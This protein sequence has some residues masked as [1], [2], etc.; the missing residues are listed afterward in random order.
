MKD[1]VA[2]LGYLAAATRFRRISE[3]LQYD[4]DKIYL[5]HGIDFKASWFSVF[6]TVGASEQPLT[7]NEIASE[8]GFTHITVK[9]VVREMEEHGLLKIS[10]HP[11]DKRAKH[12]SI[13]A[14]G[15][16]T[17]IQLEKVWLPFAATLKDLMTAGHPD[18]LN[19]VNRIDK[20]IEKLPIHERIKA[21][22]EAKL[23]IVDYRPSLKKYFYELAGPWLLRVLNG[24]LEE[25]DKFTLQNPDKAYLDTG[26]FVFFAMHKNKVIG[27]VALKRLGENT[28][29]FAKLFVDPESRKSGAA[30]KL[31]ERCICRCKEN[32]ATQLWLQTTMSMPEAH[33]LYY[34]LGF[35]DRK[36]PKEMSVLKRTEKIM[37][38]DL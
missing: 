22:D 35:V 12:I 36:A 13:T 15:K 23:S 19:I 14:K 26:G 16:K 1:I 9:N 7:V 38:L 32:N 25:E 24:K 3:K 27:C 8:V 17:T 29:E 18:F 6:Y 5:D 31:I 34:K 21:L 11:G 2:Q 4:G 20:E 10:E 30:T 33:K 37:V 28:F